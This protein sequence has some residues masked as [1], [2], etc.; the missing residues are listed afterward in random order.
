MAR[1]AIWDKKSPIITPIGE[2]LTADQW[3]ERY[4]VAKLDAITIVCGAG[5][6]N[7]SYFGVLSQMMQ[8]YADIGVDFSGCSTPEQCLTLIEDAENK[9]NAEANNPS[10]EERIAAA[11]EF[12]NLMSM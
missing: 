12:Q 5:D 10:P 1:Y 6:I 4:P 8:R 9:I 7:G 11:M 2:V 3:M